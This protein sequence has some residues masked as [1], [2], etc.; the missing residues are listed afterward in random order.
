MYP[1]TKI[2]VAIKAPRLERSSGCSPVAGNCPRVIRTVKDEEAV[3]PSITTVAVFS[4]SAGGL[5]DKTGLREGKKVWAFAKAP[6][7]F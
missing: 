5:T 6:E 3:F 1:V 7:L 4:I 2:P